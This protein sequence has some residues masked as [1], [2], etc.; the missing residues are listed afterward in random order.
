VAL[1]EITRFYAYLLDFEVLEELIV[2]FGSGHVF[3]VAAGGFLRGRWFA[4]LFL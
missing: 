4:L 2:H 3:C 1:V